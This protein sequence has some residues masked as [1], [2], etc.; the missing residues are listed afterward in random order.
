MG[1]PWIHDETLL[2]EGR[3]S[4]SFRLGSQRAPMV[5]RASLAQVARTY[6]LPWHEL[7]VKVRLVPVT[8]TL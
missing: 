3:P 2:C 8:A 1:S 4:R 6:T 5:P 7:V